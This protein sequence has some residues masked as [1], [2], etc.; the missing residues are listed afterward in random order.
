VNKFKNKDDYN[1]LI[2]ERDGLNKS[3]QKASV[4]LKK[5]QLLDNPMLY[6]RMLELPDLYDSGQMQRCGEICQAIADTVKSTLVYDTR[7][8]IEIIKERKAK[9]E[10]PM[11]FPHEFGFSKL[12]I[13]RGFPIVIGAGTGVGKTSFS[14]NMAVAAAMNEETTLFISL[15]QD[16][17]QL[18]LKL[19]TVYQKKYK[20]KTYSFNSVSEIVRLSHKYPDEWKEFEEFVNEFSKYIELVDMDNMTASQIISRY[21]MAVDKFEKNP[22]YVQIDYMQLISPEGKNQEIRLSLIETS[23]LLTAKA[24]SSGSVIIEYS[25]INDKEDFAESGEMKKAA[26]IAMILR[27]NEDKNTGEKEASV[28]LAITKSRFTQCMSS[29]IKFDGVSGAIG[30]FTEN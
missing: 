8:A 12:P 3:I 7:P 29:T 23:R 11:L 17:I 26:S 21:E 15:E 16:I 19:F 10:K 13:H 24:K 2:L 5:D 18:W 30:E 4:Q 1:K 6:D 27:R 25:Q 9:M 14:A 22:D 20:R 28:T